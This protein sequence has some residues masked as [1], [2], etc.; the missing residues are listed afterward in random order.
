VGCPALSITTPTLPNGRLTLAYSDTVAASGGVTPLSWSAGGLPAG[1]SIGAA[2][3][4][5]SGTPTAGGNFTPTITVTDSCPNGAQSAHQTYNL[6]I[7]YANYNIFNAT[8]ATM[9][10]QVGGTCTNANRILNGNSYTIAYNAA[11]V[12]FHA[13]RTG[14]NACTGNSISITGAQAQAADANNNGNVQINSS[15]QLVDR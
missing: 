10:R 5:I 1:L 12:T 6:A 4:T 3:G 15:W 11:A 8:G 2:S 13:G 14:A 7:L 9:Y